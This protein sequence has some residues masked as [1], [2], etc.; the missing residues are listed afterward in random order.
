MGYN[1]K[2]SEQRRPNMFT[3]VFEKAK[4]FIYRNARPLDFALWKYHFENGSQDD[5]LSALAAYRNADGG[6]AHA[7]EPDCWNVDSTPIGAWAAI[8][9]LNRINFCDRSHPII[10]GILKYLDSGKDFADGKWYNVVK[11]NNDH[12]HAVW[13]GCEKGEGLPDDNP[14]VSLAGFAI[15]YA[16]RSS[17]L[18]KKASEIVRSS[19]KR[20]IADPTTEMHTLRC[21]MELYQYCASAQTDW[22]DTS[23]FKTVLYDAIRQ[24][25]C[26]D[27]DKWATE[28]VCKPST[29]FDRSQLLFD[30]VDRE[31]CEKEG[32]LIVSSQQAD[33]SFP[34]TWLWYTD[35]KEFEISR[36]WW[37]SA[38]IIDNLLFLRCIS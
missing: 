7:I 36:N 14:T 37:K 18:Y 4:R 24:N 10:A 33:G 32:E 8:G 17:G 11:S 34:V 30:I 23:A 19:V 15:K 5:V 6:F 16:D 29:F 9:K 27:V 31:L 26:Y 22:V 20:F 25:I 13:W 3:E 1:R 35:Y 2:K 28:Y 12:P 21:Y 38:C